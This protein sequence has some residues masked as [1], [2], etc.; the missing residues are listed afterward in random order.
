M[1]KDKM[2]DTLDLSFDCMYD[3]IKGAEMVLSA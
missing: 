2:T 1:S 3:F